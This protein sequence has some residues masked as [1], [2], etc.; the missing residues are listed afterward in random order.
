MKIY[1]L[2]DEYLLIAYFLCILDYYS[3]LLGFWDRTE[4]AKFLGIE[5]NIRWIFRSSQFSEDVKLTV[6]T[7][8][9]YRYT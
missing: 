9:K 7:H 5:M 2:I 1:H 8:K 6:K 4:N 3:D